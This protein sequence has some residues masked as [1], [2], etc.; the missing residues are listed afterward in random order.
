[1]KRY[2]H[3]NKISINVI[4]F[5]CFSV[6]KRLTGGKVTKLQCHKEMLFLMIFV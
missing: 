6:K 5:E 2:A 1:M 3:T 4:G